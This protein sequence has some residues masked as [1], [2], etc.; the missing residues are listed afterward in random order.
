M[1]SGKPC[2]PS[3]ISIEKLCDIPGGFNY[4]FWGWYILSKHT[5]DKTV[6]IIPRMMAWENIQWRGFRSTGIRL[7]AFSFSLLTTLVLCHVGVFFFTI[8]SYYRFPLH[9][10][11]SQNEAPVWLYCTNHSHNLLLGRELNE[12][13][14]FGECHIPCTWKTTC[15]SI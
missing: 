8:S 10:P 14:V 9:V 2:K 1:F 4:I 3:Y 15:G 6:Q 5:N 13:L 12:W 7:Q 11:A